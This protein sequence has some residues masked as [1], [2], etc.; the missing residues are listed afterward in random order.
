[1]FKNVGLKCITPIYNRES[2][3]PFSLH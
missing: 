2:R 1:L 3:R